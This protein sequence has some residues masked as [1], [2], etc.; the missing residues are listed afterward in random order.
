MAA[1]HRVLIQL[2]VHACFLINEIKCCLSRHVAFV[3]RHPGGFAGTLMAYKDAGLRFPNW[4]REEDSAY[5]VAV[6]DKLRWYP[7]TNPP[8]YFVRFFHGANTWDEHH[9]GLAERASAE[10]RL[11]TRSASYLRSVLPLYRVGSD[12]NERRAP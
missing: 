11:S 9:F 1:Q 8:H 6:K 3:D 4:R 7:W 12:A 2:G 5:T 10:W